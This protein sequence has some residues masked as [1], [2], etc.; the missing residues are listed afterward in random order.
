MPDDAVGTRATGSP[1]CSRREWN[2]RAPRQ[3]VSPRRSGVGAGSRAS[4]SHRGQR[5]QSR[6]TQGL[7]TSSERSPLRSRVREPAGM[8]EAPQVT[9]RRRASRPTGLASSPRGCVAALRA[10]RGMPSPHQVAACSP[11]VA[12]SGTQLEIAAT[13]SVLPVRRC[14]T[15]D[16][17]ARLG[18]ARPTMHGAQSQ[19]P[20]WCQRTAGYFSRR[21]RSCVACRPDSRT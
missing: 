8:P 17:S 5:E 18:C 1:R 14:R 9:P 15:Q 13:W 20:P 21:F 11:T 4:P 6:T 7:G 2:D 19:R 10:L 16:G 3:P 12:A